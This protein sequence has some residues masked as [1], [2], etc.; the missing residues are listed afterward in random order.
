M[1]IES[2]FPRGV[3][4][5]FTQFGMRGCRDAYKANL[6]GKD[7][8]N[9]MQGYVREKRAVSLLAGIISE[10]KKAN[11]PHLK[12]RIHHAKAME[13]GERMVEAGRALFAQD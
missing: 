11:S 7:I 12:Y 2:T 4:V 3:F 6:E 8:F 10:D 1:K 5:T 13:A 9:F